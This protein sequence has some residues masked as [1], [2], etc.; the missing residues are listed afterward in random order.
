MANAPTPARRRAPRDPLQVNLRWVVF[1]ILALVIVPTVV[2]TGTGIVV[3]LRFRESPALILGILVTSF[4]ASVV[5]GA[6][7]LLVLARRG[8]RLAR[9]QETFLSRMSHEVLTPLAGI[10]LHAQ[11]LSRGGLP[12]EAAASIDAIRREAGRLED[13]VTRIVTWRRYRSPRHLYERT[14]TTAG[15]IVEDVRRHA[16]ATPPLRV[17]VQSPDLPIVGDPQALATALGNL[18][19][20]AQKYAGPDGTIELTLRH[21]GRMAVFS[22]V[23]DGP[24]L[25]PGRPDDLFEPFVR[26]VPPDRP[27]PG[28]SGLGLSIARQIVRAH[29]GRIAALARRGQGSLF[30]IML[31]LASRP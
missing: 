4:S 18:V 15:A 28:G 8:A 27:D 25:P 30:V 1:L 23:D 20:N 17:R 9:L 29:G 5:A 10:R 21:L 26:H 12:A 6:V 2:L 19:Q 13:L 7:L 11:I 22:V 3:L 24:G 31:P 16:L 14:R